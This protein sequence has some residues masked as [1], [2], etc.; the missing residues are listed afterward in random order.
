MKS[1]LK[2]FAE[3]MISLHPLRPEEI[4]GYEEATKLS[5]EREDVLLTHLSDEGEKAYEEALYA[6]LDVN[7]I[8]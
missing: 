8:E 1:F 4:P 5:C 3:D 7:D 6:L 2:Q